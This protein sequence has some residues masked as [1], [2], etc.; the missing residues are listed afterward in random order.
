M[1]APNIALGPFE[2]LALCQAFDNACLELSI[3]VLSI[4][5]AKRQRL[6]RI[7]ERLIVKGERDPTVLHRRAIMLF[8]HSAV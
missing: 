5:Q 1:L 4:D 3:G 7:L 2:R 8:K 6:G